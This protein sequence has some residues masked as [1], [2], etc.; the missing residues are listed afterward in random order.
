MEQQNRHR[1]DAPRNKK[2]C[3]VQITRSEAA[4]RSC[5]HSLGPKA[6][7]LQLV[8]AGSGAACKVP[9]RAVLRS[10]QLSLHSLCQ[11]PCQWPRKGKTIRAGNACHPGPEVQL[12]SSFNIQG[13]AIFLGPRLGIFIGESLRE[14]LPF[15]R[16]RILRPKP[17]Q[18]RQ[19]DEHRVL[20]SFRQGPFFLT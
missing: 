15:A 2:V 1:R 7:K 11:R 3:V 5:L 14:A 12:G 8:V 9:R 19:F 20:R 13:D 17:R 6:C 4:V 10:H 16:R 18:L